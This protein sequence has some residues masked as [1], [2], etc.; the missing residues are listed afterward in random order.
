MIR[1]AIALGAIL[2][3]TL[4]FSQDRTEVEKERSRIRSEIE[5]LQQL[6]KDVQQGQKVSTQQLQLIDR[7]ISLRQQYIENVNTEISQLQSTI[8]DKNMVIVALKS[9]LEKIR[10]EY[11]RIIYYMYKHY[12]SE[13]LLMYLLSSSDFNQAFQRTKYLQQ[14]REYRIKQA[15]LIEAVQKTIYAN[16][17]DIEKKIEDKKNLLTTKERETFEL[18]KEKE[19]QKDL[20]ADLQKKEKELRKQLKEKE[21]I[22]EKLNAEIEKL[23]RA[24]QEKMQS[25]NIYH[26]LT[27]QDKLVSDSFKSNK[28]KLPWPTK[29]GIIT[30]SFGEHNHPVLKGVKTRNNGVDISTSKNAEV[31]AVFNGTVTKVLTILG[32]NFTVIVRHGNYLTVY[33]NLKTVDVKNGD[34]VSTK[35]KIGNLYTDENAENSILHFEVWEEMNKQNPEEWLSR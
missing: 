31:T 6:L 9:D 17:L 7:K 8:D 2:L 28:G 22:A 15:R 1:R 3:F 32:A 14:Y 13:N 5:T 26:K 21:K 35:Q 19:Q 10:A 25:K 18:T 24:E 29:Y 4:G 20:V 30:E 23:I 33:Q 34:K 16:I 12:K 11:A 27:P